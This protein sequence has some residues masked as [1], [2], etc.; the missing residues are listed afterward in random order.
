MAVS[1]PA[2]ILTFYLLSALGFFD[3]FKKKNGSNVVAVNEDLIKYIIGS[4]SSIVALF[5]LLLNPAEQIVMDVRRLNINFT[6][7]ENSRKKPDEP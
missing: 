2:G 3:F 4:L 5:F 7:D 6:F 1:G